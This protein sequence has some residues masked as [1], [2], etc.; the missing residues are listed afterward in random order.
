MQ[1]KLLQLFSILFVLN[2]CTNYA[3]DVDKKRK[4][5]QDEIITNYESP[6]KKRKTEQTSRFDLPAEEHTELTQAIQD[7][8]PLCIIKNIILND[9]N[10]VSQSIIARST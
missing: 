10:L 1:K 5:E 3:M 4:F 6:L 8:A 2:F 9:P 7:K